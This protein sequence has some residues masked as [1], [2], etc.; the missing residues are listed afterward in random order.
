MDDEIVSSDSGDSSW[1]VQGYAN[2][3]EGEVDDGI[4]TYDGDAAM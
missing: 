1:D 4:G 3:G 2:Y